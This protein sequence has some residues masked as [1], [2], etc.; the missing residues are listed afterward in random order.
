MTSTQDVAAA[1]R[2]WPHQVRAITPL[3]GGWNSGTWLVQTADGRYVAKAVDDLDSEDFRNGLRLAEFAAARELS[4]GA[5]ARASSGQLTVPVSGGTL[6]LLR[7]VPGTPPDLSVP[8]QARRAGR[9]LARA[10][11]TLRDCPVG[12]EP[13]YRWL[14]E[15]VPRCLASIAMPPE[16]AAAA[17]SGWDQVVAAADDHHLEISLINGDP[18]PNSFLLNDA[19]PRLDALIDWS[20]ALRGP[21]HPRRTVADRQRRRPGAGLPRPDSDR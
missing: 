21:L 4:C 1:L 16:I 17:R 14:W 13:R 8:D 2:A 3:A 20:T 12:H 6:G 9:T 15:W 10:H 11:R 5:P 19:G 18:G 7:H